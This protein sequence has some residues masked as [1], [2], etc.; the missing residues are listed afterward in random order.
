MTDHQ[1]SDSSIP[2]DFELHLI[3][4]MLQVLGDGELEFPLTIKATQFSSSAREKIEKAGGS[5]VEVPAKIKWTRKL[6]AERKAAAAESAPAKPA[7]PAE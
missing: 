3:H 4:Q 2:F 7:T 5:I 6:G 1:E